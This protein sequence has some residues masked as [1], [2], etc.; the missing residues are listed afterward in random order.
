MQKLAIFDFDH[1]LIDDN[2]DTLVVSDASPASYIFA[3]QQFIKRIQ[4]IRVLFF[5]VEKLRPDLSVRF[6]RY[7]K[8]DRWTELMDSIVRQFRQALSCA[9]TFPL[10]SAKT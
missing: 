3:P 4:F 6:D 8:G 7:K 1:S 2:S 10:T 5:Q 9:L